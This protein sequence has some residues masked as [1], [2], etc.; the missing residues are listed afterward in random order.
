MT[1]TDFSTAKKH[2]EKVAERYSDFGALDTEPRYVFSSLIASIV[3]DG[4][5]PRVPTDIDGWQLYEME[6]ADQVAQALAEAAQQ[7]V[8]AATRD[9][10]GAVQFV[11][12][13]GL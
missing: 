10:I 4:V 6:G 3:N 2:F 1:S 7:A 13:G 9:T 5:E 11:R 12:G 8:S